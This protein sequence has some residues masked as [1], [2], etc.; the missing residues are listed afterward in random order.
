MWIFLGI[1]SRCCLINGHLTGRGDVNR[2]IFIEN[3]SV[4]VQFEPHLK[5]HPVIAYFSCML[6]NIFLKC[7]LFSFMRILVKKCIIYRFSAFEMIYHYSIRI[8]SKISAG[9][10][11]LINGISDASLCILKI[12]PSFIILNILIMMIGE[13]I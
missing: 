12:K 6:I 5:F 3:F 2:I 4:G 7:D 1:I 8:T 11:S 9:K 10:L 13:N